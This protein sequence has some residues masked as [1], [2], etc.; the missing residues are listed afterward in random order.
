M[1]ISFPAPDEPPIIATI[2]LGIIAKH[3]VKK[4]R[5]HGC[6]RKSRKPCKNEYN[7]TQVKNRKI[8]ATAHIISM[9]RYV[10]QTLY[11]KIFSGT[12]FFHVGNP[13]FFPL[14]F[15][16]FLSLME[17]RLRISYIFT[18][19]AFAAGARGQ[20]YVSKYDFYQVVAGKYPAPPS[21]YYWSS[22][23][24]FSHSKS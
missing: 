6:R 13:F 10:S 19:Q 23:L 17:L 18:P 12:I 24:W 3:R 4:F 21:V 22:I 16:L 7:D 11:W 14:V 1:I 9:K 5:I 8:W 15:F 20:N 2:K